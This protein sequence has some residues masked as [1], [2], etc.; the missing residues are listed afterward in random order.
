MTVTA[1]LPQVITLS[2]QSPIVRTVGIMSTTRIVS[3]PSIAS[4]TLL[5]GFMRNVVLENI[6]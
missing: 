5:V 6:V 1:L 2:V 3:I 4:S